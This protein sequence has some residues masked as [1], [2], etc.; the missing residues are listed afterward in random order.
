M[1]NTATTA[2]TFVDDD[3][4]ETVTKHDTPTPSSYLCTGCQQ[5]PKSFG[6][7]HTACGGSVIH[8]PEVAA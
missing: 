8:D 3:T 2:R 5:R 4:G 1:P 7:D 6:E